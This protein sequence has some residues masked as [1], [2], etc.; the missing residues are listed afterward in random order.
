MSALYKFFKSVK[1]AVTLILVIAVLSL[2]ST[3]IPQS[4]EP[5][6]YFHRY[7]APLARLI[8]ALGFHNFF[9]SM[10][11]L[12]PCV[13]FFI[14]LGVCAV[15]RLVGRW[16]RKARS[17]YGPDLIHIGLLVL[18]VGA[19]LT[20]WGRW[21]KTFYLGKGDPEQLPLGYTLKLLD[22]RYDQYP[23]GRP[24]DWVSTVQVERQG[25]PVIS[26]YPIEVNRPLRLPRLKV[27]QASFSR[28]D[29][30]LLR[31]PQGEL[32]EINNGQY[33]EWQQAILFFAGI[34]ND[35]AV[36]ERWEGHSRI[37]VYDLSPSEAIGDYTIVEL[38]S[39]ELTGLKAVKDPGFIP[40][41]VALA[42]VA[43]GLAL[44]F[45]QKRGDKQI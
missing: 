37:A 22:Y 30:A 38:S 32:A 41:I 31:D 19:L 1:L 36:F 42:I 9:K 12:V 5:A 33:F 18:V 11:F 24:K 26:S 17:R 10:L 40:V 25:T 39:R 3:L 27:Y 44:T 28:E 23:D 14:N 29:T 4:Q 15:D 6:F 8:V 2:L 13:L 35:K 20:T 34:E 45:L 16:R 43:A 21:E 7:P